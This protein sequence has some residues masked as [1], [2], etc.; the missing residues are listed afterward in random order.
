MATAVSV[1]Y[2]VLQ[3]KRIKELMDIIHDHGNLMDIQNE[4]VKGSNR[5][6]ELLK[7]WY[8]EGKITSEMVNEFA[9]EVDVDEETKSKIENLD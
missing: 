2:S 4:I 6:L 3:R 1:I 8:K 5:G 9:D 7:R